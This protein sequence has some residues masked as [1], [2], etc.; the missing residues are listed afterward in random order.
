[1]EDALKTRVEKAGDVEIASDK[2]HSLVK[3]IEDELYHLYNKD[4]GHKYKAKYRS[5]VFN[6]KDEKNN[7][8]FRKIINGKIPPKSLVNMSA[9]EMASKELQQWRQAELKHDIEKIK[10]FELD[11][12]ARGNK[13]VLKSHK[14]E[15]I[16]D[17]DSGLNKTK[18]EEVGYMHKTW[19][20]LLLSY[21]STADFSGENLLKGCISG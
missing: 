12:L 7:G 15:Q 5:L 13:L 2:L 11:Q 1:M 9:E 14:G 16:I 3:D 4:V 10:T 19:I 6:I 17:A 18:I 20:F 8:L 21:A